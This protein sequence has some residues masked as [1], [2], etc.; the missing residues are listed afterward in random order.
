MTGRDPSYQHTGSK[1]KS[2]LV[3]HQT[4]TYLLTIPRGFTVCIAVDLLLYMA[5]IFLRK[6]TEVFTTAGWQLHGIYPSHPCISNSDKTQARVYWTLPALVL[7]AISSDKVKWQ[8][9]FLQFTLSFLAQ[10][11]LCAAI[12]IVL[13]K[14]VYTW[15]WY[16]F[17][18]WDY[19][20][21]LSS[22]V[23]ELVGIIQVSVYP[24]VCVCAS[25]SQWFVRLLDSSGYI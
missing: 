1:S 10:P 5:W 23:A 12:H 14:L 13:L 17:V 15:I 18:W 24:Y 22:A 2:F 20:F 16:Q 19:F 7:N 3:I 6:I 25:V 9:I 21:F 8:L 4:S 11:G